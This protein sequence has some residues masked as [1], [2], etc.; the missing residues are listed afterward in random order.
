MCNRRNEIASVFNDNLVFT[1]YLKSK[2]R[3]MGCWIVSLFST[4]RCDAS[5]QLIAHELMV[6]PTR[7]TS[8][9]NRLSRFIFPDMKLSRCIQQFVKT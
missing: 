4:G 5:V 6:A 9:L 1:I 3:E 7:L 8:E 2:E